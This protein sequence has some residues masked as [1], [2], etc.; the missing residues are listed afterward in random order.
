[1]RTE[2]ENLAL[3]KTRSK[4]V[5]SEELFDIAYNQSQNVQQKNRKY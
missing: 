1:M 3:I 5:K 2:P 4:N